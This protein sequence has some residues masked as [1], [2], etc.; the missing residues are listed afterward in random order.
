[1]TIPDLLAYSKGS[2]CGCK[3]PPETL[4]SMLAGL[5]HNND[6][7]NI[8][9]GNDLSDDC[10]VYDLGNGQY[11]LQTVDFFTPMVNDAFVFGDGA[12]A[13]PYDSIYAAIRNDQVICINGFILVEPEKERIVTD[14]FVPDNAQDLSKQIGTVV[15]AGTPNRGYKIDVLV[16]GY[17]SP[18]DPVSVGDRVMFN[19]N[20][21]IPVQ[22]NAELRGEIKRGMLYRM[23][24]KDVHAVVDK[25][26]NIIA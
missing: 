26:S 20:D 8:V 25:D 23:Q 6:M 19:W 14:L 16:N 3:M 1:M 4:K 9:V 22:P 11:L 13:L 18:D 2:G 5:L 15:Y 24:H 21:A 17:T 10:S 7:E 12:I